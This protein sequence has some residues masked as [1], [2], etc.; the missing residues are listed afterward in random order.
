MQS[1]GQH[2]AQFVSHLLGCAATLWPV[3]LNLHHLQST[4]AATRWSL[5]AQLQS[6]NV[7]CVS[8]AHTVSCHCWA[9][10]VLDGLHK[11]PHV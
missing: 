1:A 3:D 7:R 11:L 9:A 8:L 10:A 4:H 2:G 6:A 5:V